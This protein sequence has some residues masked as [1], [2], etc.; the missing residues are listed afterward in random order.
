[1]SIILHL[2]I[3]PVSIRSACP[4]AEYLAHAFRPS[5]SASLQIFRLK[6]PRSSRSALSPI[7]WRLRFSRRAVREAGPA[8]K[9]G[10]KRCGDIMHGCGERIMDSEVYT[11]DPD[12]KVSTQRD[13]LLWP[14]LPQWKFP[15]MDF[16]LFGASLVSLNT[17][18]TPKDS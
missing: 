18:P 9:I 17:I 14:A 11:S 6:A 15:R 1:Q 2:S 8:R 16:L 10:K 12:E 7:L 5:Q 3:C 4:T 13:D